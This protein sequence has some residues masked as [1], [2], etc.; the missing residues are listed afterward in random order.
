MVTPTAKREV[1][2]YLQQQHHFS[3]RQACQLVGIAR[4]SVRYP[5]RIRRQQVDQEVMHRLREIAQQH[6]RYGYRR[7]W[8]L[9][10][11]NNKDGQ[12]INRKRV[13][14]LWRLAGLSLLQRRPKQRRRGEAAV[15]MPQRAER[16]NHVWSYDFLQDSCSNGPKLKLLTVEDEYT[17]ESL[18][19]EVGGSLPARAVVD[20]LK[21]LVLERGAP[22]DLRSAN[23]PEVVAQEVKQC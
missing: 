3:Q 2:E 22:A 18:A 14:R 8:A 7:V 19:I 9:L 13:H 11:R 1:V 21:R 17:R 15:V 16:P 20:V 10:R 12:P 23:G 4:S 5:K 6:P